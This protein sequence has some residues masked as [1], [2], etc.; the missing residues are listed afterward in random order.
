MMACLKTK[1][2]KPK[3]YAAGQ[4]PQTSHVPHMSLLQETPYSCSLFCLLGTAGRISLLFVLSACSCTQYDLAAA[5]GESA[6]TQT[7]CPKESRSR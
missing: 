1:K 5:D 6:E 7:L 4:T 2:W 3:K